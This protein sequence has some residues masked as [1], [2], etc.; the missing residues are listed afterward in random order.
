MRHAYSRQSSARVLSLLQLRRLYS[1]FSPYLV[2][3]DDDSDKK[4]NT[5]RENFKPFNAF[6]KDIGVNEQCID[7]VNEADQAD[8][9]RWTLLK[10]NSFT[11]EGECINEHSK[12]Q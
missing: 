8:K 7:N 3:S 12:G 6:F 2:Y 11:K 4:N 1:G 9:T 5:R 10:R